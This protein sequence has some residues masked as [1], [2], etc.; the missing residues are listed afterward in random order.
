MAF[1]GYFK[2]EKNAFG[3]LIKGWQWINT[4]IN[5]DPDIIQYQ[6]NGSVHYRRELTGSVDIFCHDDA[7]PEPVTDGLIAAGPF[8]GSEVEYS[9]GPGVI[10]SFTSAGSFFSFNQN[11]NID[12]DWTIYYNAKAAG[13]DDGYTAFITFAFYKRDTDDNDTLLWSEKIRGVSALYSPAGYTFVTTPAGAV[14]TD[15]R[16][17]IRVSMGQEAV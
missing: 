4:T 8:V 6:C 5:Q 14:T 15:D 3:P 2:T 10:H 7:A 12:G 17:R 16:L 9:G 1:V 11:L 13:V